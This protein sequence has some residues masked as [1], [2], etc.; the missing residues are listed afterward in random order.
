MR[1]MEFLSGV[2]KMLIMVNGRTILVTY[3]K[4]LNYILKLGQL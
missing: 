2:M 1:G 4:P 3:Y